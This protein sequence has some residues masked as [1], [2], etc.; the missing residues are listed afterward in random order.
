MISKKKRNIIFIEAAILT[1][2][3]YL[4]ALV[5]NGY[6]DNQR[7]EELDY[8]LINASINFDNIIIA[9][10]FYQNFNTTNCE[11]EK[12]FITNNFKNLK[13]IG[14]D[15][16]NFGSLFLEK[17]KN[18]SLLKQRDYFLKQISLYDLTYKYNQNC[19]NQTIIPII[20]FFNS[21]NTQLDKQAL[22]LEQFARNYQNKT[23]VFSFDIN[24]EDEPLLNSIKNRYNVTFS[25][26]LIIGNK[27]TRN[28]NNEN[29]IV[30]INAIT[31]EYKRL[32]GEI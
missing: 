27:I 6:L 3:I 2:I 28:L 5:L 15:L 14:T 21:K 20:Y 11:I 4:F 30:D 29:L 7:V 24:Y 10:R 31:I 22:I 17:N 23:I 9:Q 8:N 16:G 19:Q 1:T 13:V 32:R 25:P 26:F 18:I 12:E